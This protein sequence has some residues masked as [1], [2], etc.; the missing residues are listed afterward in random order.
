MGLVPFLGPS[1]T[2]IGILSNILPAGPAWN[3]CVPDLCLVEIF[4]GT[5]AE[6]LAFS[7]GTSSGTVCLNVPK[8]R[9]VYTI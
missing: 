6:H 4:H 5:V 7:G 3:T 8:V 2:G 9:L 1:S